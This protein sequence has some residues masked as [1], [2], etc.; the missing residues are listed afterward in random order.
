MHNASRGSLECS[1]DQH[2]SL[3]RPRFGIHD[4]AKVYNLFLVSRAVTL[5]A[6]PEPQISKF[7]FMLSTYLSDTLLIILLFRL[8]S[9][10]SPFTN[11][12][13]HSTLIRR[14]SWTLTGS[15]QAWKGDRG[16]QCCSCWSILKESRGRPHCCW[17]KL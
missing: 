8:P 1:A 6:N 9:L 13:F 16:R 7:H 14:I 3:L 2:V 17:S 5:T 12:I 15:Q 11:C 4:P 10:L